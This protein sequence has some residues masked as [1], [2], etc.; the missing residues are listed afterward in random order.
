MEFEEMQK[1]W[2]SQNNRVLYAIDET[3]L[4]KRISSKRQEALRISNTSELT[5]I[6]TYIA[7]GLINLGVM[8]MNGMNSVFTYLLTGWM[9]ITALY[10]IVIR[11]MRIRANNKFD[12]TLFGDLHHAIDTTNHQVRFSRIL[13]LNIIPIVVFVVLMLWDTSKSIWAIVGVLAFFALSLWASKF[14][15]KFYIRKKEELEQLKTK[16]EE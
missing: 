6:I 16:L 9:F 14:E 13:R 12:R 3:A 7:A 10:A 1:I 8:V 11:V 4:S 2:D 5:I 15:H